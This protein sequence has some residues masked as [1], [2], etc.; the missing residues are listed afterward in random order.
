M[1][2]VAGVVTRARSHDLDVLL[3]TNE[4]PHSLDR[5]ASGSMVDGAVVMDV[6]RDD[7]RLP[8]LAAVRQPVVLIGL[9]DEPG[10]LGCVDLD[11][12]AAGRE[13]VRHLA[14]AGRRRVGLVGSPPAVMAR[15]TSFAERLL[16]GYTQEAA[17]QDGGPL[18]TS[19]TSTRAGGMAAVAE[20]LHRA[21]DLDG[22]LVHNEGALGGVVEGLRQ[23]GREDVALVVVS[24]ADVVQALPVDCTW[25]E[26]PAARIGEIAVDMV[27]ERLAGQPGPEVR[28]VAPEL[29]THRAGA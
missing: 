13:G 12:E 2:F 26:I 22:L 3:L 5:V 16:R 6:E 23:A 25:I 1:Q 29:R 11:F 8:E 9:P 27:I 20:L 21:P 15:R 19:A 17:S 24:P 7:P 14:A 10:R 4:D 28:L 18:S